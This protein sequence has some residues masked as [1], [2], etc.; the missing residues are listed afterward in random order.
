[1]PSEVAELA[2]MSME[3]ITM[4]LWNEFYNDANDCIVLNASNWNQL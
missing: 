4:D 3:L 2:S 1:L